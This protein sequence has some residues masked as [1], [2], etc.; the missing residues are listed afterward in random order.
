[1]KTKNKESISLEITH[2]NS[3]EFS[4]NQTS[5]ES[6]SVLSYT[7]NG[8]NPDDQYVISVNGNKVKTIKGSKTGSLNFDIKADKKDGAIGIKIQK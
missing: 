2:W 6:K 1:V 4:W 5:G 3:G 7:I 8:V